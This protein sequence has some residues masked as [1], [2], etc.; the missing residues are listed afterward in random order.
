MTLR[1]PHIEILLQARRKKIYR[2]PDKVLQ[3]LV[4]VE[5]DWTEDGCD[6]CL[7]IDF[8]KGMFSIVPKLIPP[9]GQ[10][11][12]LTLFAKQLKH[13]HENAYLVISWCRLLNLPESRG[14]LHEFDLFAKVMHFLVVLYG[15]E[16]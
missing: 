16:S 9:L 10:R 7:A 4:L 6:L 15:A 1:N 12:R 11:H 8:T 5:H 14:Y 13:V 2:H 3:S